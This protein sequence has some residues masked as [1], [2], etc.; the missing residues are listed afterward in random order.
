MQFP[1]V[2]GSLLEGDFSFIRYDYRFVSKEWLIG[3]IREAQDILRATKH[4]IVRQQYNI[5]PINPKGIKVMVNHYT[6]SKN[7]IKM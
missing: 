3:E 2:K 1:R 5:P 6:Y 7:W 4:A